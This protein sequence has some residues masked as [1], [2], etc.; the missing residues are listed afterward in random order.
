MAEKNKGYEPKQR[1]YQPKPTNHQVKPPKGGTGETA[2]Q[3]DQDN[4]TPS[5]D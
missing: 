1:G 4:S 2:V 5:K 3:Q